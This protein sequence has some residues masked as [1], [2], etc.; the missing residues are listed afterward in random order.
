MLFWKNDV[1]ACVERA[2]RA[3]LLLDP[4]FSFLET[5]PKEIVRN[6]Q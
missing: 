5:N 2:L 4:V 6:V 1:A 3:C